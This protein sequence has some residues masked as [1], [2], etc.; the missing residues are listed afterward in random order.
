MRVS[1]EPERPATGRKTQRG[2]RPSYSTRTCTSARAKKRKHEQAR[3]REEIA[4]GRGSVGIVTRPAL[5]HTRTPAL[6]RRNRRMWRK[7]VRGRNYENE[8]AAG[9]RQ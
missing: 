3:E 1:V 8:R 7:R 5:E 2:G 9:G 4:E 6:R